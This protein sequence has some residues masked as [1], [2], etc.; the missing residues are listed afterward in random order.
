[1]FSP[2]RKEP[3]KPLFAA[4]SRKAP[5]I[6]KMVVK[7]YPNPFSSVLNVDFNL[8]QTATVEVQLISLNGTV[9]YSNP[10]G[11]L[12]AGWYSLPVQTGHIAAG[13]YLLKLKYGTGVTIE[14]IMKLVNA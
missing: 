6:L 12:E 3:S 11:V 2:E 14:K 8:L 10:A 13:T 9:V 1:M 4:L 5:V 7:A